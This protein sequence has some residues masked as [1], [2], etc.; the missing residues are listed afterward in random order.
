MR[1]P[2][3]ST[4]AVKLLVAGRTDFAVLDIH[5]LGLAREK[6]AD[7]VGVFPLVQRPLAAVIARPG[8]RSPRALEGRRVGVTGLPSDDA[9]LSSVV[10]GAGGD[11]KRVKKVTI[12][13]NA[14]PSLLTGRVDGATAFWNAEGVA[15][16]RRRPGFREFRVDDYGAPA[17]PELVVATT[18]ATLDGRPEVVGRLRRALTRGYVEAYHRPAGTVKHLVAANRGLD[19]RLMRAELDA[20]RPALSPV[21]RLSRGTLA[22]WAAW[23]VRF[24][25]LKRAPNVDRAF[26]LS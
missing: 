25:I 9:V 23:D 5:D 6:G 2:G 1:T 18:R 7:L 19:A 3:S 26:D 16:R 12:G 17:Y 11:P 8:T 14:V 13:F 10:R 15:L 22:A 4:D 24:G 21:G 20:L